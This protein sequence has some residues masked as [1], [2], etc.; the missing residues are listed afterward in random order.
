MF[1][2]YYAMSITGSLVELLSIIMLWQFTDMEFLRLI[3][4]SIWITLSA[5][6]ILGIIAEKY[7]HKKSKNNKVNRKLQIYNLKER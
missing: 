6:S 2:K 4:V 3:F 5:M 7:H 1:I